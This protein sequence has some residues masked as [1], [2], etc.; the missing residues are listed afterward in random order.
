MPLIKSSGLQKQVRNAPSHLVIALARETDRWE[1][2]KRRIDYYLVGINTMS[3]T[4]TDHAAQNLSPHVAE[5]R[6]FARAFVSAAAS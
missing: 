4:D 2:A 6:A 3:P 5:R 1:T